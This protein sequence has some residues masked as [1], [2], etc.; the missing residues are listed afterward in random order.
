MA[1][2]G[3][4]L[5][6]RG[7]DRVERNETAMPHLPLGVR[8]CSGSCVQRDRREVKDGFCSY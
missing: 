4:R 7:D 2:G 1:H 5:G 3:L 6:L 8:W